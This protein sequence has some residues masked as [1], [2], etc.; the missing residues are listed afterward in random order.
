MAAISYWFLSPSVILALLGKLRGWERTK[1]TP[2][3]DWKTATVD[4][5]I[6]AKNEESS[7]ALCLAS[8]FDQDLRIRR[9]TVI[10]DASTDQTAQVVRRYAELSERE[11]NLVVRGESRGKTPGVREQCETSNADVLFV[12]DADTVLSHRNYASRLT[13]NLFENAGVASACGEVSPLTRNRR[14]TIV[15]ANPVL[16]RIQSELGLEPSG[17]PNGLHALLESL[18][19]MYRT[20]LYVFLQRILY[21]G[22]MKMFGSRLNPS[23]CAVAYRTQRLRECFAYAGPQMGDNLTNSED[24]FIGH[25]FSWKGWRNVQVSDV[26]C[27]SIEPSIERLP[28]QLYL[29]SS[30]FFQSLYYFSE[31]PLSPFKKTNR[32]AAG[33]FSKRPDT[34]PTGV[35]RRRIQEQYRAPWGEDYTRRFGRS[36][37]WVDLVSLFEKVTYPSLLLY[38][39]FFHHEMFWISIGLEAIL[40]TTGVFIVADSGSRWKSAGMM[41][42]ATPIRVLTLGVDLV[43]TLR[44][45][46][47]LGTGN[48]NWR[49]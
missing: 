46:F 48:R 38:F 12:L 14:R 30:S 17:P 35:Q 27:E 24:V 43:T 29:W 28:R 23:G 39:A 3:F 13:E 45:L 26:R 33:L 2:A 49:K 20:S 44:Y 16:A 15:K 8:L 22:H 34:A 19:V 42:A 32:W 37:G 4:V 9:V 41:L 40:A 5:V 18:T 10:D 36:V 11:I 6:P 7:I 1:P 31:L 25:F 21:D 47:D